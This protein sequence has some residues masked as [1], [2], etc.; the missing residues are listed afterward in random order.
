M[1]VLVWGSEDSRERARG[2]RL[3]RAAASREAFFEACDVL[4]LHLRLN[5]DDAR[6]RQAA[7]TCCG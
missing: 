7:T 5:D 1:Q 3:R 2:R 6:H 4:S